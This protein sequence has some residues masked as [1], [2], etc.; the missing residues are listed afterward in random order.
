MSVF[1][2]KKGLKLV[3]SASTLRNKEQIKPKLAEGR[4]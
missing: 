1:V 2:K 3:T 4:R